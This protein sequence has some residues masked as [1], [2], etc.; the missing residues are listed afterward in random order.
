MA[1]CWP[2]LL[3]AARRPQVHSCMFQQVL[4]SEGLPQLLKYQC[5]QANMMW[6]GVYQG[7]GI[8]SSLG[9]SMARGDRCCAISMSSGQQ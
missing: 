5:C 2:T 7:H 6:L 3:L 9:S 4:G 8:R 1:G